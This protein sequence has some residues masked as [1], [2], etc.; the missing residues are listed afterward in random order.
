[1]VAGATETSATCGGRRRFNGEST[2]DG[3]RGREKIGAD[4]EAGVG[5]APFL[6]EVSRPRAVDPGWQ[7]GRSTPA[8]GE[9]KLQRVH[10]GC[11]EVT[12]KKIGRAHV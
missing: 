10:D 4:G 7:R 9:R 5:P 3:E 1:M 2:N 6:G 12:R 8:A 11:G